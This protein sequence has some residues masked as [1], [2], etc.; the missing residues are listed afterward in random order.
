MLLLEA[1]LN[2][3]LTDSLLSIF[4]HVSSDNPKFLVFY[5]HSE[6]ETETSEVT[7][8]EDLSSLQSES[9]PHCFKRVKLGYE[10]FSK[11]LK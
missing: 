2:M 5:D 6:E 8:A 10:A 11:K 4:I 7:D 9:E 1:E 3:H